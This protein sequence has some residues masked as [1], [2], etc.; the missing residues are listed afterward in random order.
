MKTLKFIVLLLIFTAFV[1]SS[2]AQ[3]KI[4]LGLEA[5]INIANTSE[6]PS[7]NSNS[8]IGLIAGGSVDIGLS[9]Q[10]S[11]VPGI[12]F[13]QHGN[14]FTV[15]AV[16]VTNTANFLQFPALLKVNFPLT[17]I[18]PYLAGGP[19]LG[20]LL[21]STQDQSNATQSASID[22]KANFETTNFALLFAGGLDFRV[23]TKTNLFFQ[24]GYEL[25]LSNVSKVVNQTVK[26]NGFE[27]TGG[28][29][30]GL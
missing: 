23:A 12:R 15:N 9:P 7:Q 27:I 13:V 2:Q 11:I 14:K 3:V 26:T 6:T 25:G 18:K 10:I 28:V 22:T 1:S 30:F 20:I 19:I 16:D 29:K 8:K 17:E 21:S 24:V 5:G 4:A